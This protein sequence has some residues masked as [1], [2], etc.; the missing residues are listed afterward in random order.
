MYR[1][2]IKS[3]TMLTSIIAI[4]IAFLA[5]SLLSGET[6]EATISNTVTPEQSD[7]MF[8]LAGISH[9]PI[10]IDSNTN[11][12]D[13]ATNEGWSGDGSTGNPYIIENYTIDVLGGSGHCIEIAG[14]SVYF[15]IRNCNLT[16]ADSGSGIHLVNVMNS[17]LINNTCNYNSRGIYLIDSSNSLIDN[18]TCS[19]SGNPN[20]G[21]GIQLESSI[22]NIL[23]NN[24]CNHNYL[25]DG[26]R[27]TDY[28]DN[29]VLI[30]NT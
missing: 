6:V 3:R 20:T 14:T 9:D 26:I 11:F 23:S 19:F 13:T 27:L 5:L 28:S 21:I 25:G 7:S 17:Q 2:S 18:N 4:L 12:S 30:N 15:I 1:E 16:G 10:S 8:H 24:I 22:D 29:N